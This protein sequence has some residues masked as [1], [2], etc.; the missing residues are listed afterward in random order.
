MSPT[1]AAEKK[2]P[3]DSISPVLPASAELVAGI[4]TGVGSDILEGGRIVAQ[5]I[6]FIVGRFLATQDGNEFGRIIDDARAHIAGAGIAVA[7]EFENNA[8]EIAEQ[9]LQLAVG[10]HHGRSLGGVKCD[11]ALDQNRNRMDDRRPRQRRCDRSGVVR[12][13]CTSRLGEMLEFRE[14]A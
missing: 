12:C 13:R 1:S 10:C 6:L 5:R 7:I 3:E 2:R 4:V 8:A 14:V 9:E 11:A